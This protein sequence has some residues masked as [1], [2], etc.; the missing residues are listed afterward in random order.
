[1]S[2]NFELQARFSQSSERDLCT[3]Y[4][5]H[6]GSVFEDEV[7]EAERKHW[8]LLQDELPWADEVRAVGETDLRVRFVDEDELAS[9]RSLVDQLLDA[10]AKLGMTS[11]YLLQHHES[12]CYFCEV[13]IKR[14]ILGRASVEMGAGYV[15]EGS[16]TEAGPGW[17][18]PVARAARD[19]SEDLLSVMI[20]TFEA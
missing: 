9:G 18:E 7:P 1:M 5:D 8:R 14:L 4:L 10:L 16:M 6:E 20:S 3:H 15:N 13:K 19:G 11:G 2:A 17:P 12:G